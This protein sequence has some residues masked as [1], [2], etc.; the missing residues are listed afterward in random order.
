[1][2]V[3]ASPQPL[4]GDQ[5]A[6]A[7]L[8]WVRRMRGELV[9]RGFEDFR[10]SDTVVLRSLLDRPLSIVALARI[11]GVARQAARKFADGLER[12][13]YATVVNDEDDA[14]RLRVILSPEGRRYA[15]AV[16]EVVAMMNCEIEL[17]TDPG[18]LQA[19]RAVLQ[20]VIDSDNLVSGASN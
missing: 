15:T 9:R 5:L 11:L 12:R 14:R 4:F 17:R 3:R 10:R 6:L 7:R 1:M 19:A 20:T 18:Q 2:G 13:G 16:V 8:V